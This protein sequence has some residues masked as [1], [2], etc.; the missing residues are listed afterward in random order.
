MPEL[1][2]ESNAPLV[3]GVTAIN[4]DQSDQAGVGLHAKSRGAG[5]VGESTTWMGVF[6]F[7]ESTT[8]GHGVMGRAVGGGV[9]AVGEAT[10]GIGVFAQTDT[11]NTA[12]H[13]EHKG[14]GH[15]GFFIGHV[16][17]TKDLLVGGD[18][19]LQGADVAEQFQMMDGEEIEAGCVVVLAGHDSLRLSSKP[20]DRCVAGVVSGA[21][22]HRPGIV[23]DRQAAPGRCPVA[24]SGKVWC[25]VDADSSPVEF[26]QMLTTSPTP[27]HAM[28]ATDPARAFGAVIGKA[29]ASLASG[30]GLVPVLVALQ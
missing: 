26:G 12:L 17:V 5:V 19:K 28:G 15:A 24:L 21:G 20:Y 4:T 6:G 10:S 29:L 30:R 22:N 11:G 14:G 25:K 18:V 1:V 7:T 27:G 23:L 2:G 8:G 3:P 9:G 16:S 13:A